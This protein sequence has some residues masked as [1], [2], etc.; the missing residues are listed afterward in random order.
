MLM[1][2]GGNYSQ[3]EFLKR[4]LIIFRKNAKQETTAFILIFTVEKYRNFLLK[5]I[6][7]YLKTQSVSKFS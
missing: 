7:P 6:T 1:L 2:F 3:F 4:H 5:F